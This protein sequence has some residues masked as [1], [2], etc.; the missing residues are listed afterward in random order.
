MSLR[1]Q[2]SGRILNYLLNREGAKY[3][4]EEKKREEK[5]REEE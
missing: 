1:S 5:R 4:K 2:R 3:A